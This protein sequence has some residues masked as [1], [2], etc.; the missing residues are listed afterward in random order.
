[1]PLLT[2]FKK[3]EDFLLGQIG[4]QQYPFE[5]LKVLKDHDPALKETLKEWDF[6]N[7]WTD[8][9]YLVISMIMTMNKHGGVGLAANQVGVPFRVAVVGFGGYSLVMINP[10][11]LQSFGEASMQEGCLSSPG[12]YLKVKRPD[13]IMLRYS[14][15]EGKTQ[16]QEFTGLT[17]RIIQHEIDHLNG[18]HFTDK[19][20]KGE[21][22]FAKKKV[23][24]NLKKLDE[25]R[26]YQMKVNKKNQKYAA[27]TITGGSPL[28]DISMTMEGAEPIIKPEVPETFV[29]DTAN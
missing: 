27:K 10:T 21:L 4:N 5:Y 7:P 2:E 9:Q 1:M 14:D 25:A 16:D 29:I 28:V 23:P 15:H 11:I 6:A 3:S 24:S 22:Y 20:K 12:L 13:R 26:N 19:V 18:V 17:A 8:L